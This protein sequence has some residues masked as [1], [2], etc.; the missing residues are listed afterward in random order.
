MQVNWEPN[1]IDKS[2]HFTI[3]AESK[4]ERFVLSNAIGANG[5]KMEIRMLGSG[6]RDSESNTGYFNFGLFP[7]PA[8]PQPGNGNGN[9]GSK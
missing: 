6:G 7:S 5:V 2:I 8:I 9:D 1:P 4:A 3:S